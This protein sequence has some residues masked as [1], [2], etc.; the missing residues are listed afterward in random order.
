M[1][2]LLNAINACVPTMQANAHQ[3]TPA[4]QRCVTRFVNTWANPNSN[5]NKIIAAYAVAYPQEP[6]PTAVAT[7]LQVLYDTINGSKAAYPII[8]NMQRY[9][10][11]INAACLQQVVQHYKQETITKWLV[12]FNART[13]WW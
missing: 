1:Q 10:N 4:Q 11:G 5:C 8:N 7:I 12:L 3:L 6:N 2:Q 9:T 13:M